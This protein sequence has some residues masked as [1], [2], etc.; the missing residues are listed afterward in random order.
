[1]IKYIHYI[2]Q[3]WWHELDM[4]RHNAGLLLFVL[5][6]PLAYPLLYSAIYTTEQVLD[7]PIAVVDMSHTQRSRDYIRRV[8][9][10]PT[11]NVMYRCDLGQAQELMRREKVYAILRIPES[12]DRDIVRGKQTVVGFYSDLRS[13]LYYKGALL[14]ATDA[15]LQMNAEIKVSQYM[16]GT[17]DKVDE[18]AAHPVTSDYVAL[19]NPQSGVASFLLPAVMMLIIQQLLFLAVSTSFGLIRERNGYC[20]IPKEVPD[21]QNPICIVLGKAFLYFPAFF[22][23]G[24]YMYA[25]VTPIFGFLQF[26][27]YVVF[28][29]FM[30]PFVLACIFMGITLSYFIYRGED[31]MLLFIF[32]SLPLLFL[33][34]MSWPLAAEPKF[35]QAVSW[36]FPSS[37]ATHGYARI[38]AMGANLHDV[39]FEYRGLWMQCGVYG[40]TSVLMYWNE[41]NRRSICWPKANATKNV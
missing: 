6:V 25:G 41:L 23:I 26:G 9:A 1:M 24:I 18:I 5:V 8:D 34:G 2:L 11:V 32:M 29:K 33:S 37:F 35:W 3:V 28:L 16:P 19:F 36:F 4:V 17:T 22:L 10:N 31:A 13:M 20:G 39:A 38:M 14:A 30:V 15:S 21:Y 12:F 7:V 40:L 27:D